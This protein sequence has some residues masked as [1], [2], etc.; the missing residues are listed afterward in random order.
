[1]EDL[2]FLICQKTYIR[3]WFKYLYLYS[4]CSLLIN[5]T[6]TFFSVHIDPMAISNRSECFLIFLTF[7]FLL[8]QTHESVFYI[9]SLISFSYQPYELDTIFIPF[10]SE[11]IRCK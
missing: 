11:E 2:K 1:M 3:H 9:C 5:L 10:D 4:A 8:S 7:L 6:N